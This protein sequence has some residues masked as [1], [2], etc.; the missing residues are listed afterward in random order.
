MTIE[1]IK[2]KAR[3]DLCEKNS[4]HRQKMQSAIDSSLP[5]LENARISWLGN[6]V[7]IIIPGHNPINAEL[8]WLSKTPRLI[9][10]RVPEY[11]YSSTWWPTYDSFGEALLFAQK[12]EKQ[13]WWK[14]WLWC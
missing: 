4:H 13:P 9:R 14:F 10:F 3:V 11:D 2:E 7:S 1:E 12:A 5:I 6:I 8:D